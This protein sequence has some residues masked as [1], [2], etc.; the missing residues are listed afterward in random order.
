MSLP[1]SLRVQVVLFNN[2]L[3]DVLQQL[4]ALIAAASVARQEGTLSRLELAIGDSSLDP[5]LTE[6]E[7]EGILANAHNNGID[8]ATYDFFNEN[9]GSAGGQNRLAA[10]SDTKTDLILIL[11]PDTYPSPWMLHRQIN[12]FRDDIGVVEGRQLP[13]E[14]PKEHDPVTRD[15]SW[16]S[17][18]CAMYKRS[19]FDEVGGFDPQNFFLHCDDVDISWRIRL[20]GYRIVLEPSATTLHHKKV[21]LTGVMHAPVAER[22][23]GVLGGLMLATRFD[24]PDAIKRT[25]AWVR[26]HGDE[27]QNEAIDEFE[28]RLKAGR[29]PKVEPKARKVAQFVGTEYAK[30]RF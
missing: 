2:P 15:V 23:Y 6:E 25:T 28:M 8:K 27:V 1:A 12:A 30:H 14:H 5:C 21:R 20:L 19:V 18:A 10:S 3:R 11:N 26:T 13:L 9:L 17:T 7:E 16:A 24:A 4:Q 29:V 22:Y